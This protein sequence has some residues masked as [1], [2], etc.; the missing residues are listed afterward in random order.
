MVVWGTVA[1]VVVV[2]TTVVGGLVVVESA[3]GPV[4]VEI[5]RVVDGKA[6][7]LLTEQAPKTIAPTPI[8]A[9]NRDIYQL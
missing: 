3:G 4:V 7:G 6:P 5:S 2:A 1:G 8:R 9:P